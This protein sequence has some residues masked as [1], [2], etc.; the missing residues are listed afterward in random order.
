M[1]NHDSNNSDSNN[2]EKLGRRTFLK[3]MASVAGAAPLAP[4]VI[5][6]TVAS[7]QTT[8]PPRQDASAH[9]TEKLA[10]YAAALRYEDLPAAVIQRTKECIIDAVATIS[11]GPQL[12]WTRMIIAHAQRYGAGGK[13]AILGV[14]GPAVQAP[15]AA[16]AN[17]ASAHAF[18]LDGTTLPGSGVHPGAVLFTSG[19]AVAQERGLGGRALIAAIVAGAEVVLR[20]G[21]ATGHS[22]EERGFHAPGTTGPFGSAVTAGHLHGFDAGKMTNALGIAGSLCGGLLEFVAAGN[23]AM[24]KRLHLGRASESGVLA[25]SLADQGFTGPSSVIE[26]KFGFLHDFCDEYDRSELLRGL[27]STFFTMDYLFKP[28]AAHGTGQVPIEA[29]MALRDE[30]KFTGDDVASITI[31]GNPR[32]AER[33]NILKPGDKMMAQY[34]APFSVALSLYRDARDPRSFDDDV[35][36]DRAILDLASRIKLAGAPGQDRTDDTSVVTIRLKNGRELSRKET[37]YKGMPNRPFTRAQ[38]RDKFL[39]LTK[40]FDHARM[41]AMFERLENIENERS[42]DWLSVG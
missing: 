24:V 6:A 17:G 13:S 12:P 34:S 2:S 35:I 39:L 9:E 11:Y 3:Q 15:G 38:L 32:M 4:A 42:L 30:H 10:A 1:T 33:N 26:G 37:T 41:E 8:N 7:A 23:G 40:H 25:A 20:V 28:Y 36:H 22:N 31:V 18:E 16:L 14:S 21:H 27:G 29:T 19:F 5:G